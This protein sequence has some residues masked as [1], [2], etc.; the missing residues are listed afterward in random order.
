M[1]RPA[2]APIA[3]GDTVWHL[4]GSILRVAKVTEARKVLAGE[5][6][7]FTMYRVRSR[8]DREDVRSV[9]R[10]QIFKAPEERDLLISELEDVADRFRRYGEDLEAQEPDH[11]PAVG[12]D[13]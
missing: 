9:H 1:S 12:D 13:A 4:W 5:P 7:E 8:F 10:S 11:V 6:H 2:P 3:E